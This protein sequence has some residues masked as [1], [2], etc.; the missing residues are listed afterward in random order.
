MNQ[1]IDEFVAKAMSNELT[2]EDTMKFV[3]QIMDQASKHP[4]TFEIVKG[5]PTTYNINRK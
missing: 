5:V 2:D 3:K 4:P 1:D